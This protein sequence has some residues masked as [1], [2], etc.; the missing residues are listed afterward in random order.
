[1]RMTSI[2][3]ASVPAG[4]PKQ[5]LS[6]DTLNNVLGFIFLL[7]GAVAF[8]VVMFGAFKYI[9]SK[10]DPNA[11]KSAKETILYALV[12]LIVSIFG[13]SIVVF[14]LGGLQ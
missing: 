5:D 8:L 6:T 2:L 9:I 7:A 14:V 3:S 13:Y 11:I 1:M 10:G 12:G 4:L